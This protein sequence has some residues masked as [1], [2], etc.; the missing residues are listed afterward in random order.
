M[1]TCPDGHASESTDYCDQCGTQI[2]PP[3]AR[4]GAVA[5]PV[6]HTPGSG[7]RFCEEC[8]HD[9][10]LGAPAEPVVAAEPQLAEPDQ[11]TLIGP[12]PTLVGKP[13]ALEPELPDPPPAPQL[14]W[15]A[16]IAADREL[17]AR[18]QARNGPDADQV[19]FPAY[20]PERRIML[21]GSDILIGKHSVSQGVN[22]EIDLGIPPADAGVSRV[23]AT[24]HLTPYA[25]TLIDLGSTN[26]TSLN[27][28]EDDIP[29]NIPV[30]VH[31]GDRIHVGAWTTITLS[32]G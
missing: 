17:Y 12:G 20:F 32:R 7:S 16:T 6:C 1:V 13:P 5:C 24:L 27:D 10:V 18:V 8:G 2:G 4:P 25:A 9:L 30:Q 29:R 26:G 28:S 3:V 15:I 31:P 21:R 14:G 23:H 11:P 22:P 19:P